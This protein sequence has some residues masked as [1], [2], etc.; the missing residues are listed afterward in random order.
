MSCFTHREVQEEAKDN[1][2]TLAVRE[3][4]ERADHGVS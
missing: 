2:L 1:D 3:R 4:L